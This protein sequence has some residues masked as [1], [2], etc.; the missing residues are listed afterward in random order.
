MRFVHVVAFSFSRFVLIDV[1]YSLYDYP[2]HYSLILLLKDVFFVRPPLAYAESWAN[3]F[4][5]RS[6][7]IGMIKNELQSL[8]AYMN[9]VIYQ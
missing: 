6:L 1:L 5:A 9:I 4:F 7:P 2:T 3:L 8:W